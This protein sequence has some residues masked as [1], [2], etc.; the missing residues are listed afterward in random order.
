M[1][2]REEVDRAVKTAELRWARGEARMERAAAEARQAVQRKVAEEQRLQE[3]AREA[4]LVAAAEVERCEAEARAE[5]EGV[6]F[7]VEP[8]GEEHIRGEM[9]VGKVNSQVRWHGRWHGRTGQ[10]E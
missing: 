2:E 1:Q 8:G 6:W 9:W 4:R 5:A 7:R 10:S 3:L